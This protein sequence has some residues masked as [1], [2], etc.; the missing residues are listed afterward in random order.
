MTTTTKTIIIKWSSFGPMFDNDCRYINEHELFEAD[1]YG[2]GAKRYLLVRH[3]FQCGRT[4]TCIN[5]SQDG[6]LD[7]IARRMDACGVAA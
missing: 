5:L 4:L 7:A 1:Y 3:L 6:N 2:R